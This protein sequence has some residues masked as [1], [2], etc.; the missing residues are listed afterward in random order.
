MSINARVARGPTVCSIDERLK[1]F[2]EE[3]GVKGSCERCFIVTDPMCP[4]FPHICELEEG[5]KESG[6]NRDWIL[7]ELPHCIKMREEFR[8]AL[9]VKG[10]APG[11]RGLGG[12][13]IAWFSR[14]RRRPRPA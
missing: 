9:R 8:V 11:I 6:E 5:L 4:D 7:K 14:A 12:S 1:K 10:K 3:K 13:I 2:Y